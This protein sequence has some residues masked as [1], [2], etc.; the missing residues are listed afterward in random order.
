MVVVGVDAEELDL[1]FV[2][3]RGEGVDHAVV[4]EVVALLIEARESQNRHA[5][6]PIDLHAHLAVE[7]IAVP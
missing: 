5:I 3:K 6:M 1:A 7:S 2:Q 4:I